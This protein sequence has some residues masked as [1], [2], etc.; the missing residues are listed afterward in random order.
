MFDTILQIFMAHRAILMI[1]FLGV[2]IIYILVTVLIPETLCQFI[3][4]AHKQTHTC[5]NSS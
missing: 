1:T 5:G 4:M 3:G 2:V